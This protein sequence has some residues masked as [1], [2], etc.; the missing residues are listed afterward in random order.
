MRPFL[1][2]ALNIEPERGVGGAGARGGRSNDR[3]GRPAPAGPISR[4]TD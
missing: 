4:R 1:L 3:G 2:A